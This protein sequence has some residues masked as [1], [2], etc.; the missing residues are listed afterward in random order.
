MAAFDGNCRKCSSLAEVK[1][2]DA[3][4][5][6]TYDAPDRLADKKASQAKAAGPLG[7]LKLDTRTINWHVTPATGVPIDLII[8]LSGTSL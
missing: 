5:D 6:T 2:C 8:R 3:E 1:L 7:C 4:R